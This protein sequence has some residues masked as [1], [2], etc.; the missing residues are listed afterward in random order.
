MARN[1]GETAMRNLWC[2]HYQNPNYWQSWEKGWTCFFDALAGLKKKD[3]KKTITIRNEELTV[4]DAIIRQTAHY[5]YHVGQLIH[6]GKIIK[7][8]NWQN[9]S[10]REKRV[11][12]V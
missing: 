12:N 2:P 1:P 4:M 9:L 6:I 11:G 3:L 5:P 7:G 8:R 10:I